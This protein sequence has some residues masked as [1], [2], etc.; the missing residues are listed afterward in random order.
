MKLKAKVKMKVKAKLKVDK[1]II[2]WYGIYHKPQYWATGRNTEVV[3]SDGDYMLE[4]NSSI[5]QY[6]IAHK[7]GRLPTGLQGY[8]PHREAA[9]ERMKAAA[10]KAVKKVQK[11]KGKTNN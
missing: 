10:R 9:K 5:D 1:S 7:S 11:A 8:T 2:L 4:Y 6:R 3:E